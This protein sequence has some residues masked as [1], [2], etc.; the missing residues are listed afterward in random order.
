MNNDPPADQPEIASTPWKAV[1][2]W[3]G[4]GILILLTAAFVALMSWWKN[5]E[6]IKSAGILVNQSL[7]IIPLLVF[8]L[9]YKATWQDLGYRRFNAL[10]LGVGCGLMLASLV[11]N[12][13][14]N[15][16]FTWLGLDVQLEEF[17]AILKEMD[18]PI[19]LL[20]AGV[21]FAPFLE[22]T[23]FR[24]FLYPAFRQSYGARWAAVLS[25]ALFGVA[26][27]SLAA[28]IPTFIIGLIF[29]FLYEQTKSVWAGILL[30]ALNNAF[31]L[32]ALLL[33]VQMGYA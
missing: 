7:I 21:L 26:H 19:W 2:G 5:R 16:F 25:S 9:R 14:N 27:L 17:G 3:V 32:C 11:V 22:E 12:L 1:D 29:C 23:F 4:V 13:V 31:S 28:L 8:T 18:S 15:L 30:H 6:F 20:L 10:F 33:L 24:G